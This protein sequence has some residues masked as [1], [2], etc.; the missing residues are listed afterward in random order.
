VMPQR[1]KDIERG[2]SERRNQAHGRKR[3]VIETRSPAVGRRAEL[4]AWD[5]NGTI[6]AA[7]RNLPRADAPDSESALAR[8]AHRE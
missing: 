2:A 1:P 5:E 7:P 6:K 4:A 3:I 8:P